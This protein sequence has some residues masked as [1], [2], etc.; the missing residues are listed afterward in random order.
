MEK[1]KAIIILT[2]FTVMAVWIWGK[3]IFLAVSK[4]GAPEA[5]LATVAAELEEPVERVAPRTQFRDW[6]RD[7]FFVKGEEKALPSLRLEGIIMDPVS[8]FAMINGEIRKVGDT[9]DGA[10]VVEIREDRVILKLGKKEFTL[11][12]F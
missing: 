1:K 8:P 10:T 12:L 5:G 7:P 6:G 4:K 2:I 11:M 9:M 3:N